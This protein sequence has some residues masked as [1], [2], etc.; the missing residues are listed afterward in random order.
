MGGKVLADVIGTDRELA[1]PAV[2][3]DGELDAARMDADERDLVELRVPFDD[4]VSDP[5]KRPVDSL[6]VEQN[7]LALRHAHVRRP[8]RSRAG[9]V[10]RTP[11]RPHWTGLKGFGSSGTLAGEA[12]DMHFG[13]AVDLEPGLDSRSGKAAADDMHP[14]SGDHYP[15]ASWN[16]P[17]S[18]ASQTWP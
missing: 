2:G 17:R 16:P 1:M 3:E 15:P 12:D 10:I 7:R 8:A 4:L 11:F 18:N 9:S 14:A 5:R 13:L 6:A